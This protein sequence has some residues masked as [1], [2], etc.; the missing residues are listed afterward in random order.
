MPR[1][2]HCALCV[3]MA[4]GIL[5]AA[6]V[7]SADPC[8]ISADEMGALASVDLSAGGGIGGTGIL[9]DDSGLGGTGLAADG[10]DSGIGGTGLT[11]DG[12]DSGIGGTGIFGTV[13]AFGSVCVNGLRVHYAN[14]A[15]V[16]VNGRPADVSALGV[17]QVVW[18]LAAERDGRL[19][20]DRIAVHSAVA[21]RI[22][23]VDAAR[24]RLRV[25]GWDIIVPD[26]S[27]PI[28]LGAGR[29][30]GFASLAVGQS[31]DGSGLPDADGAV[32]ASRVVVGGE[33]LGIG[34]AP[35]R[36]GDLVSSTSGVEMLSIEGYVDQRLASDRVLVGGLEVDLSGRPDLAGRVTRGQRIRA[37]GRLA[38]DGS[39][40]VEWRPIRVPRLPVHEQPA[41]IPSDSSP[42]IDDRGVIPIDKQPDDKGPKSIK[43]SVRPERVRPPRGNVAPHIDKP[44]RPDYPVIDRPEKPVKPGIDI[45]IVPRGG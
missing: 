7:A 12:D 39:L 31:V 43:P 1:A 26:D 42:R 38:P 15:E 36:V 16:E 20:T 9:G 34:A 33:A 13:T 45:L 14:D 22:E 27:R 10:D 19:E 35:L 2:L 30:R 8:A 29:Q 44:E 37:T 25:A 17:G 41:L 4:A 6:S 18:I 32:V 24:R 23:A 3:V 40:R 21:G 28:V 5:G 11:A